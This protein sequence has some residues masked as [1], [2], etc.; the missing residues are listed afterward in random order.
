MK[1]IASCSCSCRA[2][3]AGLAAFPARGQ[4]YVQPGRR[5]VDVFR[6]SDGTV[7]IDYLMTFT[8]D[9]SA[10]PMEYVD[11]GVPTRGLRPVAREGVD[12]WTAPRTSAHRP[13]SR[14]ASP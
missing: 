9:L 3:L 12:R 2:R 13:T 8:N 1:R 4:T 10:D 6:Q 14:R 5:G 11:V 7:T